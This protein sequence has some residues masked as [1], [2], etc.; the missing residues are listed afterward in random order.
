MLNDGTLDRRLNSNR[1]A[2]ESPSPQRS[3]NESPM[4]GA[5]SRNLPNY[6]TSSGK[7]DKAKG[8]KADP[9]AANGGIGV[10]YSNLMLGGLNTV[11]DPGQGMPS[12]TYKGHFMRNNQHGSH[13]AT[14]MAP[15]SPDN[16]NNQTHKNR[17]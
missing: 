4:M 9:H 13:D 11:T 1:R 17:F 3:Y 10:S 14:N 2:S 15:M 7:I 12:S 8:L 5:S 6:N 16:M